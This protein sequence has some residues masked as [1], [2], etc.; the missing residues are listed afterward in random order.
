M[1]SLSQMP[2]LNVSLHV[3]NQHTITYHPHP[4]F[5][6]GSQTTASSI[7]RELS[8]MYA[9]FGNLQNG[10]CCNESSSVDL[11][12]SVARSI[13]ASSSDLGLPSYARITTNFLDESPTRSIASNCP[14]GFPAQSITDNSLDGYPTRSP[15]YCSLEPCRWSSSIEYE[16]GSL[17]RGLSSSSD[18]GVPSSTD[19]GFTSYL[20]L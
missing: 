7:H 15:T 18:F 20:N 12:E 14:D 3:T 11:N 1:A 8:H 17:A 5:S 2:R 9:S 19:L 6:S 4:V 16:H 13:T 10:P